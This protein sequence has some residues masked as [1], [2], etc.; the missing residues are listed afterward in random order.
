[1]VDYG[2]SNIEFGINFLL[3]R[4]VISCK[5]GGREEEDGGAWWNYLG[6]YL[7]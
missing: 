3:D 5:L 2:P 6:I 1:M 7:G 4:G